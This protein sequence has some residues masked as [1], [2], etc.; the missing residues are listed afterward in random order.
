MKKIN[1]AL[2]SFGMSGWVFH[3]P[4]INL[5]PGFELYGVW[6]RSAKKAAEI[7][8]S[9]RS[10][11]SLDEMLADD[12]I[13]LVV[14]NTPNYTHFDFAQKALQAGKHV[15][16]E[17]SF[18]VTVSE[19]EQLVA[20]AKQ[21]NKKLAVYQNRRWDSDLKTVKKVLD[22]GELGEIVEAEFHYDRYNQLLS[23]K[24]HKETSNPGAGLLHDLG[25]HLIDQAIYLFGMPEKVFGTLRITRP[26]SLVNDY[27]DILLF[28]PTMNLRLKAGLI[29]KEPQPS[30]ILHGRNGS[31]LKPRADVQE[32][33]LK[34]GV[35]PQGEDWGKEPA[36]AEGL[37][38]ILVNGETVRKTIPSEQ[39]DYMAL[40]EGLFKAITFDETPLVSGEDG[41]KVMKI[42][43]AV[44]MSNGT[45]TVIT[46]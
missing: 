25:P 35:L 32:D 18:T 43:E 22:S 9:I 38:N 40:Y 4:F 41:L 3:A 33:T 34:T 1:T 14:V 24:A 5:H 36:G 15:L 17:K 12:A 21:K 26:S 23:P 30:F 10:F 8:P 11:D 29:V 28:Y 7:Y 37:L 16:V 20:L 31:F 13:D 27:I 39:G 6:E 45:G 46:V 42:I 44:L 2:C 19:A